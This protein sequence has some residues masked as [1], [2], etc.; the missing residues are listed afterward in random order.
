MAVLFQDSMDAYGANADVATRWDFPNGTYT[1]TGG[2]YGGKGLNL[3]TQADTKLIPLTGDSSSNKLFVSTSIKW[4]TFAASNFI[5]TAF[6]V[7]DLLNTATPSAA[8]HI[9]VGLDGA[10]KAT[11]Y[12]GATII[13]TAA[14][15]TFVVGTWYRV[16]LMVVVDATVGSA[17]LRVDG[18]TILTFSGNTKGTATAGIQAVDFLANTSNSF[19]L[20]DVMIWNSQGLAPTDFVG[21][22]RIDA[23]T[24]TGNGSTVNASFVGAGVTVAYQ[25]VDDPAFNNADTD[26]ILD[27]VI[28]DINLFAMADLATTPTSVIGIGIVVAARADNVGTRKIQ[29]GNKSGAVT[30]WSGTDITLP[31]QAAYVVRSQFFPLDLATGAAWTGAGVNAIEVGF[32]VMA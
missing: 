16:E 21:D 13:A 6:V 18:V 17:E 30:G 25:A 11:L 2:R 31:A 32:K 10:G 9:A 8:E 7:G 23:Y 26:Y 12:R 29:L 24:P 20:D 19:A 5:K 27:D 4:A 1:A 28:N 3:A 22:F 14:T 15:A